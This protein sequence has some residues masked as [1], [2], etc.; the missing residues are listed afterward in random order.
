MYLAFGNAIDPQTGIA[1]PMPREYIEFI[2]CRDVYH[3][4]PSE[5]DQEDAVKVEQHIRFLELEYE[6]R[7]FRKA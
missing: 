5:L 6:A 7:Q 2:L 1:R 3:C 4:T